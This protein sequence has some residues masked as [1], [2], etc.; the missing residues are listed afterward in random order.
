MSLKQTVKRHSKKKRKAI[1]WFGGAIIVILVSSY[2]LW[3][4]K[5]V[6]NVAPKQS[7][8][9]TI[10]VSPSSYRL[11]VSAPGTLDPIR[12]LDIDVQINSFPK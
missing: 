10:T 6:S 5:K 3:Y 9:E 1:W 4:Q 2:F 7:D 8:P 11:T 12:K